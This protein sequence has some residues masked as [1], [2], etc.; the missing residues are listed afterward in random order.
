VEGGRQR[1]RE[2]GA[3]SGSSCRPA[4]ATLVLRRAESLLIHRLHPS[5]FRL[6]MNVE[7]ALTQ[8]AGAALGL[9][10]RQ[11]KWSIAVKSLAPDFGGSF[12]QTQAACRCQ[13]HARRHLRPSGQNKTGAQTKLNPL[14]SGPGESNSGGPQ[15]SMLAQ[16]ALANESSV[17]WAPLECKFRSLCAAAAANATARAAHLAGRGGGQISGLISELSS[18]ALAACGRNSL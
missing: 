7:S 13:A 17:I 15:R 8:L 14:L 5:H 9:R 16:L 11:S 2:R 12:V 10:A 4:S 3:N 6:P 1:E 18:R